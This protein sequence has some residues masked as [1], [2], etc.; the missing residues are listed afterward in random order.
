MTD[1]RGTVI[2]FTFDGQKVIL[3]KKKNFNTPLYKISVHVT[4]NLAHIVQVV[5]D[6]YIYE[7]NLDTDSSAYSYLLPNGVGS[8]IVDFQS[9]YDLLIAQT[10]KNYYIYRRHQTNLN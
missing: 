1:D 6:H 10:D 5:G 8:N 2:Q 9:N 3:G 7:I 4:E